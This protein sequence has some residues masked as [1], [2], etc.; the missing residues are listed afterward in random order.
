LTFIRNNLDD[1]KSTG[2]VVGNLQGTLV[3]LDKVSEG[4]VLV[5][6]MSRSLTAL[7]AILALA[8]IMRSYRRG[9]WHSAAIALMVAPL[10]LVVLS[11]WGNEILFR[12]Y[13]FA[14]PFAAFFMAVLLFPDKDRGSDSRT[15]RAA[16]GLSLILLLGFVFSYYGNEQFNYFTPEEFIAAEYLF[17]E[18]PEGSLIVQG[19]RSYPGLTRNHELFSYVLIDHEPWET[20]LD[21]TADPVPRLSRWLTNDIYPESF[22]IITRSQKLQTE[23]QGEMPPGGLEAIESALLESP[24]FEVWFS[25]EDA[26]IFIAAERGTG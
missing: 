16:L 10:A 2:R 1:L 11:P 25:N 14:L 7:V 19:S 12:V 9:T 15:G 24:E 4:Q 23:S 20:R 3:N 17:E 6:W 18:A 21:L 26:T 8:G 13:L 5:S 22:L